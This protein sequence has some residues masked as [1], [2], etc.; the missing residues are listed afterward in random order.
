MEIHIRHLMGSG[1]ILSELSSELDEL[2]AKTTTTTNN[3]NIYRE[4]ASFIVLQKTVR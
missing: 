3:N 1:L 2:C 4:S